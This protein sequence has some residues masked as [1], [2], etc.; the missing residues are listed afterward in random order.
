MHTLSQ[1]QISGKGSLKVTLFGAS[2]YGYGRSP[3]NLSVCMHW[4]Q[5]HALS[6]VSFHID[7][8]A[9]RF[10]VCLDLKSHGYKAKQGERRGGEGGGGVG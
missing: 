5:H 1:G 7:I 4:E 3:V 2:T 9:V 8:N 10:G 6:F